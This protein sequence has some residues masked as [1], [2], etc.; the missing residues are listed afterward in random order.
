[1]DPFPLHELKGERCPRISGGDIVE[2]NGLKASSESLKKPE[3]FLIDIRPV[4][5]FMKGALP[6]S[7]HAS[8]DKV[9]DSKNRLVDGSF[10]RKLNQNRSLVKVVI[11]NRNYEETVNF[12]NKLIDNNYTRVCM[13][14]K[15][16][17]VFQTT[18]ILRVPKPSDLP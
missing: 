7:V 10:Q 16:I 11:G 1:M 8:P 15:G 13:L 9:F 3:A 14:H 5:E 18:G 12:A 4:N 17:E 6:S 2:L